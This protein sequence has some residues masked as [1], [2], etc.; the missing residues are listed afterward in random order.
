[1][2][3][4]VAWL[5]LGAAAVCWQVVCRVTDGRHTGLGAV[6]SALGRRWPGWV[7]L[8]AIWAFSG[9]HLFARYTVAR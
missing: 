8:T 6:A 3:G 4:T 9:W 5:A 1:V 7:A 2:I